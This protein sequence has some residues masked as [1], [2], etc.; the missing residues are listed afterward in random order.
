[1]QL[2]VSVCG[3]PQEVLRRPLGPGIPHEFG[4]VLCQLKSVPHLVDAQRRLEI[5]ATIFSKNSSNTQLQV[6]LASVRL[7]TFTA[8]ATTSQVTFCSAAAAVDQSDDRDSSRMPAA[9]ADL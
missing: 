8:L 3:P 5:Q 9:I 1:M 2:I 4:L 6:G 7:R